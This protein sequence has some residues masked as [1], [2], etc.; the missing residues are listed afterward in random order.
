M[1]VKEIT[2]LIF[3]TQPYWHN[4]IDKPFKKL[5]ADKIRPDLFYCIEVLYKAKN[6]LTIGELGKKVHIPKQQLTI[7]TA[8]LYDMGFIERISDSSDRR[9]IRLKLTQKAVEYIENFKNE[10]EEYYENMLN[11]MSDEEKQEF[12]QALLSMHNIF[13]KISIGGNEK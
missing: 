7:L 1:T 4:N 5:F 9:L 10:K 13:E 11:N 12:G 6:N 8:K 2:K 3:E